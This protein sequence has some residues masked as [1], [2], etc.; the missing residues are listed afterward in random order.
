MEGMVNSEYMVRSESVKRGLA[1][2]CVDFVSGKVA[3]YETAQE[4]QEELEKQL[5]F[6]LNDGTVLLAWIGENFKLF[7]QGVGI[8]CREVTSLAEVNSQKK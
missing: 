3:G 2:L 8:E 4:K 7:L 5:S 6:A 1:G